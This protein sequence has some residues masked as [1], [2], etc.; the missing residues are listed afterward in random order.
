MSFAIEWASTKGKWSNNAFFLQ[1][2][3]PPTFE[4][5][6]FTVTINPLESDEMT[7]VSGATPAVSGKNQPLLSGQNNSTF[8]K[9]NQTRNSIIIFPFPAENLLLFPVWLFLE[10]E[11]FYPES[12]GWFSPLT[13][14]GEPGTKVISSDSRG[15]IVTVKVGISKV[16]GE[17]PCKKMFLQKKSLVCFSWV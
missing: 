4:I 1:G 13:A 14:G 7:F 12:N 10:V 3:S 5:P 15:Y 17:K 2:S 16:S 6:T 8:G 11:L 9:N